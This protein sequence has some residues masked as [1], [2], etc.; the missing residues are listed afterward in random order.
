[1]GNNICHI[2]PNCTH[3]HRLSFC[4]TNSRWPLDGKKKGENYIAFLY[5]NF[6]LVFRK[7][8]G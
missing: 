2:T 1:M 5:L 6:G 7:G 4:L 8:E 3:I